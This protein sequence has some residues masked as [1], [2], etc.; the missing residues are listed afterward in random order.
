M[1]LFWGIHIPGYRDCSCVPACPWCLCPS[2]G[3]ER[4]SI[5]G[6]M[7]VWCSR[8]TDTGLMGTR[9]SVPWCVMGQGVTGWLGN[10]HFTM[11]RVRTSDLPRGLDLPS[12]QR[13]SVS[14]PDLPGPFQDPTTLS[15]TRLGLAENVPGNPALY[16]YF[17]DSSHGRQL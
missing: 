17:S 7:C 8:E 4:A 14:A 3:C 15:N 16:L 12:S 6:Q 10:T 13:L 5:N 11:V 9:C 1:A 2:Q